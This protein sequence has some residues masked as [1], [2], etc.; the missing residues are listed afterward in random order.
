MDNERLRADRLRDRWLAVACC[1]GTMDPAWWR[2]ECGWSGPPRTYYCIVGGCNL[3]TGSTASTKVKVGCCLCP[4]H[5]ARAT[6]DQLSRAAAVQR[7]RESMTACIITGVAV[8]VSTDARPVVSP[9]LDDVIGGFVG[10]AGSRC[11]RSLQ[12][13]SWR[14]RN[15]A[16][17]E[18]GDGTSTTGSGPVQ[19]W[20]RERM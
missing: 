9:R 14:P 5:V 11:F 17:D 7:E 18:A 1:P 16:Q 20:E 2:L 15:P 3:G 6:L 8:A 4:R 19:V 12:L 13:R 10:V